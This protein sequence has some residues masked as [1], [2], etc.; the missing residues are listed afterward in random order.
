L[1][2][3]L[4]AVIIEALTGLLLLLLWAVVAAGIAGGIVV[5]FC[6]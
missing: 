4:A 5:E 1:E 2:S 6:C 3:S